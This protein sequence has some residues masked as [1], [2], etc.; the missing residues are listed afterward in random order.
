MNPQQLNLN[1][2]TIKIPSKIYSQNK[3]STKKMKNYVSFKKINLLKE[4]I[5]SKKDIIN[6]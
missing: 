2:S 4:S 1:D 6:K 3:N 5:M